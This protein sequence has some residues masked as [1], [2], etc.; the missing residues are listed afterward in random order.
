MAAASAVV[1]AQGV[2]QFPGMFSE[3]WG[4]TADMA[5]GTLKLVIGRPSF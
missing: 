2:K 5:S 1:S 3:M 4:V